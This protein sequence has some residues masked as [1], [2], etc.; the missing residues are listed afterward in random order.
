[1]LTLTDQQKVGVSLT[2]F[3]SLF[4][5]LGILLFLD[6]A[7]MAIGNLL[8]LAGLPLILGATKTVKFFGRKSK[9]TAS[10]SFLVGITLVFMKWVIIGLV[11]EGFGVLNLFGDFL[12]IVISVLRNLPIIGNFLNLPIIRHATDR[13][14]EHRRMV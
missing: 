1:M 7:L 13:L 3:G 6:T 8:F 11:L 14:T 10:V 12:P 9:R 5:F 2:L 4:F